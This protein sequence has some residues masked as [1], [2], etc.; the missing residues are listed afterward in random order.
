MNSSSQSA[1]PQNPRSPT[2]GTPS[3]PSAGPVA[4]FLSIHR[5]A[6]LSAGLFLAVLAVFWQAGNFGFLSFDDNQY[7]PEIP[8]VREGLTPS[9]FW[10]AWTNSHVGQWHPLT[11][12]SF[13]FDSS[14]SGFSKA[15]SSGKSME[16]AYKAAGWF[17]FHNIILHGAAAAL[18]FLAINRLTRSF[19]RSAFA[20]AIFALH[21]LRA[22]SVAWV[23]ERKDVLSGAFLMAIL[24]SY[25]YYTEKP[26]SRKR[27]ILLCVL[28]AL[29]LL[30]KPM[31][32]TIPFVMVLLDIW[33]LKR[34]NI[35][36]ESPG[37]WK[38][39]WQKLV[40]LLVEKIPLF[41]M[42]FASAI[43]AV[44]AVGTPFRPI[45]I[46]PL[47]PRL[48]YIPVSYVMYLRQ[49]FLPYGLSAHY[50]FVV[51]GPP[52]W[53][54]LLCTSILIALTVL[55][56]RWRKQHPYFLLGWFWFLGALLP[57]IGLVPGGIQ[58]AADRYTYVPQIGMGIAAAWMLGSLVKAFPATRNAVCAG[59]VL[60]VGT[61]S[62]ACVKQTGTWKD[63]ESL[64]THSL[65]VT[66]DN[67]YSSEKLASAYQARALR[68]PAEKAQE[69]RKEAEKLF[70]D[71]VRLNPHLVGSLNN[72]SVL[73]RGK[74]ELP[75]AIELQR[76]AAE[77]HPRWGLM[78]RNLASVLTQ[79]RQFP[80]AVAS[81]EKAIALDANDVESRY[82]LGLILSETRTDAESLQAALEQFRKSVA[83]QPRFA[84]A[85]F[86]LGNVLY[87]QGKVDEAIQSFRKAIEMDPNHARAC[88]NLA[89][90]LGTK[91]EKEEPSRLYQRA[92]QIDGNYL[93]AY[94]NLAEALL[95]NGNPAGAT[96]VWQAALGR[97]PNDLPSLYRLA[98][99][100]ATHPDAGVRKIYEPIDLAKK[101]VEL[102]QGKEPAFLDA[103]AA[104]QA[105][106][107][108]F[109]E[110]LEL[111][112]RALDLIPDKNSPQAGALKARQ[113]L[114]KAEKAYR[115]P[116]P[117]T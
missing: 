30:S 17:H 36:P 46:L 113:E 109:T 51:E 98:W 99:I 20:A 18:L 25:A 24:W 43:G 93:E 110:S 22:E 59:A 52:I 116:V 92:I 44:F 31:L 100:L 3:P 69:L 47:L 54:V 62:I 23:T 45:P 106:L 35:E 66:K 101:G 27:H 104:A 8:A 29:G 42:A 94:R 107:G 71:A 70:R 115:E 10:W 84:E 26:S 67:D 15:L 117:G 37:A 48:L 63:D 68:E 90:L 83:L 82:N 5:I 28:F 33:P 72:L 16:E 79:N 60:I 96:Q 38:G 64:W 89:S 61:F 6:L 41:V 53:K 95:R 56:W 49:F 13:I 97:N 74:G 14:V 87:R 2:K 103:L 86:S 108:K 85:H 105:Q 65:K 80:E 34:L 73:L 81:F 19:W 12:L 58:I 91:G 111:V 1:S 32:V 11:T 40:P 55:A 57:V 4:E 39:V 77:E 88:N 112:N 9:S 7:I 75:E 50:P 114:Y 76:K 102:T 21:P 78:H